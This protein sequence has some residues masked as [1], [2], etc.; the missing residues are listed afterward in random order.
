MCSMIDYP[1]HQ[2]VADSRKAAETQRAKF[3]AFAYL[4]TSDINQ[5]RFSSP[6]H[7]A[8]PSLQEQTKN[9]AFFCAE[10]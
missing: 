5:V 9:A 3:L 1:P 2:L 7:F 10:L 6:C 4:Y 8:L